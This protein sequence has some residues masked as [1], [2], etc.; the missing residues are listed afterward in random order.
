MA[1]MQVTNSDLVR[2]AFIPGCVPIRLNF[3][4][5][6]LIRPA[7]CF[8]AYVLSFHSA[9]ASSNDDLVE[10]N[11][12]DNPTPIQ[13]AEGSHVS[14]A[15]PEARRRFLMAW[16]VMI[17]TQERRNSRVQQAR[18]RSARR[19]ARFR[20]EMQ[21]VFAGMIWQE[22]AH[23]LHLIRLFLHPPAPLAFQ[24]PSFRGV[25]GENPRF[26]NTCT[27]RL[28]SS[29]RTSG[30]PDAVSACLWISFALI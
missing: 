13:P 30:T 7:L 17:A 9:V 26:S 29:V 5:A 24:E 19:A 6:P 28:L 14:A 3:A 11:G 23:R 21:A 20:E 25:R 15:S 27:A 18:L 16:H 4:M 10:I 2:R 1:L 12:A 22:H 8:I